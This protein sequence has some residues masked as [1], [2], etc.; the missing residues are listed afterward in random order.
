MPTRSRADRITLDRCIRTVI[1]LSSDAGEKE[2]TM[3]THQQIKAIQRH[4]FGTGRETLGELRKLGRPAR[5]LSDLLQILAGHLARLGTR[6]AGGKIRP[7][8]PAY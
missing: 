5:P 8:S 4:R 7:A 6:E 3:Y 2:G 1:F